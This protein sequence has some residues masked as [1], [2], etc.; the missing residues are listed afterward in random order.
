MAEYKNI[1]LLNLSKWDNPKSPGTGY[2]IDVVHV[3]QD[4][5]S[6][7]VGVEKVYYKDDGAKRFGKPLFGKDLNTVW[8]MKAEIKALMDNPPP[9]PAAPEPAPLDTGGDL[10]A[11]GGSLETVP[12]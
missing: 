8:K 1:V 10:G 3:T 5:K 2:S 9:I 4:G 6:K 7:G 11:G 12:F